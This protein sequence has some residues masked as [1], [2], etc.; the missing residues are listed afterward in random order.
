MDWRKFAPF[1]FHN[2]GGIE[3]PPS[4]KYFKTRVVL[5][6]D[7]VGK[8]ALFAHGWKDI[9]GYFRHLFE[10]RLFSFCAHVERGNMQL[11]EGYG[12][13]LHRETPWL[14]RALSGNRCARAHLLGNGQ[15][16]VGGFAGL[17]GSV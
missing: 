14:V 5:A 9:G 6:H 13:S 16:E 8:D 11:I 4:G 2:F 10:G 1:T 15:K 12:L 3:P 7:Q 17:T